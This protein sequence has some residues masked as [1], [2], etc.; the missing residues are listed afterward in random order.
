MKEP[1]FV[2]TVEEV[3]GKPAT[4]KEVLF[5]P[6]KT[7]TQLGVYKTTF[8]LMTHI[9]IDVTGVKDLTEAVSDLARILYDSNDPAKNNV[10]LVMPK[11]LEPFSVIERDDDIMTRT[12]EELGPRY[13][14]T[15]AET[16]LAL[17]RGD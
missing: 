6:V 15:F 14:L 17:A 10:T 16:I 5:I 11:G 1:Y 9:S 13:Q 8:D 3:V 7:T 12:I 2:G 4:N